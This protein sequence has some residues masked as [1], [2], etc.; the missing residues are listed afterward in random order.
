VTKHVPPAD[1]T[2]VAKRPAGPN[3]DM[4]AAI[5]EGR[6]G[7]PFAVLGMQHAAGGLVVRAFLPWA[8]W[9]K[10]VDAASSDVVA[11]L[12]RRDPAGLFAGPIPGR[13]DRFRYRL[14]AEGSLGETEFEDIYRFPP[15]LGEVDVYLL[16]EGNHLRSWEKLGAHRMEHDGVT[17][18][19]FAVWAPNASRVSVVGPQND[20]DGRRWPMRLRREAGIW[21]IFVPGLEAGTLYKYEIKGPDGALLPLKADPYAQTAE[22]APG[23]ASVVARRSRHRWQDGGWLAQ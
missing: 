4:V 9:V 5:V 6:H 7:D 16:A 19:A 3:R 8:R 20:W 21:E 12:P 17:G 15:V 14:R 2:A 18:T 10:V 11:E 13:S 23:T 22:Q 1:K